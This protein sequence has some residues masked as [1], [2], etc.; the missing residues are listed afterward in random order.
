[1]KKIIFISG[2]GK[3]HLIDAALDLKRNKPNDMSIHL[4]TSWIPGK[5]SQLL[6]RIAGKNNLID[7]LKIRI[8]AVQELDSTHS[9]FL[10]EF[11]YHIFFRHFFSP[12]KALGYAFKLYGFL[13]AF[14]L[15]F[16][17]DRN[18]ILHLRSGAGFLAIKIARF[19]GAKII[20][21]HSIANPHVFEFYF[22]NTPIKY[23]E[24]AGF[25]TDSV[26]WKQVS[27]DCDDADELIVNSDFVKST[28]LT[29][30]YSNDIHV[31]YLGVDDLFINQ[32]S[33][34]YSKVPRKLIFL[35][36]FDVRKGADVLINVMAMFQKNN[37]PLELHV[38][39][40][41]SESAKIIMSE[42]GTP[43]SII[44][45]GF[46][47]KDEVLKLLMDSDI[48]IFPSYFEGCAR[49]VMEALAL[50]L[51]VV[52]TNESGAP[53]TN[54]IDGRLIKSGS[55]DDC[56]LTIMELIDE[57]N[58]IELLGRNAKELVKNNYSSKNY[59]LKL[60]DIYKVI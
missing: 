47:S 44:F 4:M 50:G 56:Y 46:C 1:L 30:N 20:V 33:K 43:E 54:N 15:L 9:I 52:A 40:S 2:I 57:P 59:A 26:L 39:G 42:L 48:F 49:A 53:I 22:Q 21:D 11:L 37:I 7:R 36:H 28:F 14:R 19:K 58:K 8:N 16:I 35:G 31:N 55:V 51:A 34:S 23:T 32:H 5:F 38:V 12:Q 24:G 17:C 18:T 6:L 41:V 45:H 29:T 25:D 60:I 13:C 3:L 10:P 27:S